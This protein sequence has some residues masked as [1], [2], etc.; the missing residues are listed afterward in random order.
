MFALNQIVKGRI[1][2]TFII[3]A[4]RTVGGEEGAQV[5]A[6]N[7]E[8]HAETGQGEMFLPFTAL[9]AIQ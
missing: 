8:N 2:G 3:L 4:L 5:K 9:E 1:A 7:P 6:V